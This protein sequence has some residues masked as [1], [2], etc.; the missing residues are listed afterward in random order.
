MVQRPERPLVIAHRGASAY[1]P[2]NTASAYR[3]AIEQGADMIEVDRHLSRDGGIV[4][5]HDADLA[6][7][8]GRGE[9][10]ARRLAAGVVLHAGDSQASPDW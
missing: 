4:I 9:I 6:R 8:G 10:G 7:L 1:R 3:L 2:E 5:A